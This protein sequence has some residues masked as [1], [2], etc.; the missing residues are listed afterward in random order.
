MSHIQSLQ[1]KLVVEGA[2]KAI[3]FYTAAFGAV[4]SDRV[5]HGDRVV[6]AQ[7][8]AGGAR[9]TL[10]D[11]GDGDPAPTGGGIPVIMSLVV[12]DADAVCAQALAVFF[13]QKTAYE[14]TV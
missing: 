1:P 3:A 8:V 10:K 5:A 6:H 12:D 7:L 13:K 14:I 9:F 2:D 11:A 4:V